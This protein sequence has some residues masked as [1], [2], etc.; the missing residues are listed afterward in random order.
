[1][2]TQGITKFHVRGLADSLNIERNLSQNGAN[3]IQNDTCAWTP[4]KIKGWACCLAGYVEEAYTRQVRSSQTQ[5][6][7]EENRYMDYLCVLR[8]CIFQSSRRAV[9]GQCQPI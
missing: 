2:E 8:T 6:L 7:F 9:S 1:M 4:N 3:G 5:A